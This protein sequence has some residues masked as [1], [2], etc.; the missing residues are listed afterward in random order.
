MLEVL[1]VPEGLEV[2]AVVPVELQ[3]RL[4]GPVELD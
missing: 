3:Q 1:E 2:A 4:V